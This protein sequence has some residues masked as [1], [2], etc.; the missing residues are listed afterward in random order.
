VDD[1]RGGV[2]CIELDSSQFSPDCTLGLS[3]YSHADVIFSLSGVPDGKTVKGARRPRGRTDWPNVGIFAQRA[4][5][6]PNRIGMTTCPLE[7]V[8]GLNIRVWE[9]DAMDGTPVLDV[10]PYYKGFGPR[11]EVREPAWTA[12]L[13]AGYC[14]KA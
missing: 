14:R 12:E 11:G 5:D 2:V 7:T 9:L 4:K 3:D 1:C 13:M 8:E 6:R 10:K